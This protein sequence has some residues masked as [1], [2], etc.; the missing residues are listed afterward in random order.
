MAFNRDIPSDDSE[1]LHR[2]LSLELEEPLPQR[3]TDAYWQFKRCCDKANIRH[4]PSDIAML[5]YQLGYGKAVES[6]EKPETVVDKYRDGEMQP[7]T[8]VSVKWRHRWRDGI[9]RGVDAYQKAIVTIGDSPV[10]ESVDADQV[11][12]LELVS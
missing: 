5:C 12:Q 7:G 2:I 6:D 9:F 11:R 4:I 8:P 1:F 10:E 3:V